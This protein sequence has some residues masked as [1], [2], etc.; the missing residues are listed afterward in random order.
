MPTVSISVL[1]N[2]I[3]PWILK[4][5]LWR[6]GNGHHNIWPVLC[7]RFASQC[8][9][10][11]QV[12]C[13]ANSNNHMP[14]HT[15]KNQSIVLWYSCIEQDPMVTL[16][17]PFVNISTTD[18]LSPVILP[19]QTENSF[20]T[21]DLDIWRFCPQNRHASTCVRD[22]IYQIWSF[23]ELFWSHGHQWDG[24]TDRQACRH[25]HYKYGPCREGCVLIIS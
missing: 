23:Y 12:L 19:C 16:L 18:N 13:A 25:H 2:T 22:D 3:P 4:K 5:D 11:H 1:L 21:Y 7:M 9:I 14:L 17:K 8:I 10:I 15:L 6:N 20:G 24:L